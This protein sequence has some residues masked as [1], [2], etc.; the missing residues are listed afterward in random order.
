MAK[1]VKCSKAVTKK[2]PGIQCS[3]CNKWL[4]GICAAL[5]TDQ[6]NALSS[7]DSVDWKCK[8]CVGSV[9]PKRVSCILPDPAEEED[10]TDNETDTTATS[11]VVQNITKNISRD[12]RREVREIIRQE[13]QTTLQ[14]YS[15]KID[16]YEKKMKSFE[17]TVKTLENNCTD[18]KNKYVNME[19]KYQALEQK[20]SSLEQNHLVNMLEICGVDKTGNEDLIKITTD[21]AKVINCNP[22]DVMEAY[23]KAE[24]PRPKSGLTSIARCPP[25]V[26]QLRNGC[27]ANWLAAVKL[28][29]IQPGDLG[30]PISGAPEQPRDQITTRI[31]LR[32]LLTPFNSYLLWR[33][34]TDLKN[35]NLCK[36]VWSKDGQILARKD[37][38]SKIIHIRSAEDIVK[39]SAQLRKTDPCP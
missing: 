36:F 18:V 14:Y 37:E 38:E 35:T 39:L 15:D 6:L 11:A 8:T 33:A 2:C 24:N 25:I 30:L 31:Y 22:R 3:K 7:T 32:E 34:K 16:D 13:L 29:P 12:L 9:R 26:V 21:V 19:L 23:R 4:H 28:N 1:C 5:T 10:N 17:M 27:R 20:I